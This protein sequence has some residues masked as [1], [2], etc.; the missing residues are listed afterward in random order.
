MTDEPT[1]F[2]LGEVCCTTGS[3]V[4]PGHGTWPST[5]QIHSLRQYFFGPKLAGLDACI[6][7]RASA[8]NTETCPKNSWNFQMCSITCFTLSPESRVVM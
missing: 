5:S 7:A 2:S 3:G 4:V 6:L 8:S 1:G